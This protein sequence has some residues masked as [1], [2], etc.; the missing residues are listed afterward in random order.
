MKVLNMKK[1]I[2]TG[3][4]VGA[5]MASPAMAQTQGT[6]GNTSTA[7]VEVS[8]NIVDNSVSGKVRITGLEN[9]TF[10]DINKSSTA[11]HVFQNPYF[12]LWHAT[13]TFR[14]TIN[15]ISNPE[16]G[17]GLKIISASGGSIDIHTKFS[18]NIS[19]SNNFVTVSDGVPMTGLVS[20]QAS[21]YNNDI[22]LSSG[23]VGGSGYLQY[24]LN[25]DT[26]KLPANVAVGNYTAIFQF[27]MAAE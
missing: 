12:C 17:N 4:I 18:T 14:L 13:P 25:D 9:P 6:A 23:Q 19:I 11:S 7:Q 26:G 21:V 5:L 27:V 2:I 3:A 24:Y 20:T 10:G 22:C 1:S 15:R 16:A 8:A